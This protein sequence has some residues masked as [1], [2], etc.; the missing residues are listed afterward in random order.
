MSSELNSKVLRDP[1]LL[2]AFGFG[3]GLAPFAPGTS[4]YHMVMR[5]SWAG[6]SGAIRSGTMLIGDD[7]D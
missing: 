1:V 7:V 4:E 6:S 5:S 2:L 3:T